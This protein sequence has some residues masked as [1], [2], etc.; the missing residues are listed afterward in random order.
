MDPMTYLPVRPRQ[1]PSERH[2]NE[3]RNWG[4]D[5]HTVPSRFSNDNWLCRRCIWTIW[6]GQRG[7]IRRMVRM[8]VSGQLAGMEE[9]NAQAKRGP[10]SFNLQNCN[11]I[12]TSGW[13]S[14]RTLP[15]FDPEKGCPGFLKG[16]ECVGPIC[17]LRQDDPSRDELWI[18]HQFQFHSCVLCPI[19][20][21]LWVTELTADRFRCF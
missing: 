1:S 12:S 4:R 10:C 3:D 9:L 5:P 16:A 15:L 17:I 8:A 2:S 7:P 14:R 13:M 20:K 11:C 19:Q 21:K 6:H 18:P